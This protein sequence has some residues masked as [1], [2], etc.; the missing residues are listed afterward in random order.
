MDQAQN[1]GLSTLSGWIISRV[2]RLPL[3][4]DGLATAMVYAHESG[5]W[6]M[7]GCSGDIEI[8]RDK[9]GRVTG[10]SYQARRLDPFS[11][12]R[13]KN[14]RLVAMGGPLG[15]FFVAAAAYILMWA[16]MP[17]FGAGQIVLD[18]ALY[19]A[20]GIAAIL[21]LANLNPFNAESDLHR[22]LLGRK[23]IDRMYTGE[24]EG[25][26]I[27]EMVDGIKSN[28]DIVNKLDSSE[29]HK[30][31]MSALKA[32]AETMGAHSV[33]VTPA[34]RRVEFYDRNDKRMATDPLFITEEAFNELNIE[35]AKRLGTKDLY[36]KDIISLNDEKQQDEPVIG[37]VRGGRESSYNIAYS[38]SYIVL[39]HINDSF[40]EWNRSDKSRITGSRRAAL[41][42]VLPLLVDPQAETQVLPAVGGLPS[43]SVGDDVREESPR[44]TLP[45]R[46]RPGATHPS[47]GGLNYEQLKET[48]AEK[49]TPDDVTAFLIEYITTT[50]LWNQIDTCRIIFTEMFPEDNEGL[51]RFNAIFIYGLAQKLI[52]SILHFT[53][54]NAPTYL[55]SPAPLEG[56]AKVRE[57]VRRVERL[58]G[59][60]DHR[61]CSSH[62]VNGS[63]D[64]SNNIKRAIDA[65]MD[66]FIADRDKF[67]ATRW[68]IRSMGGTEEREEIIGHIKEQLKAYFAKP[69]N[70]LSEKQVTDKAEN[71]LIHIHVIALDS[72]EE[73]AQHLNPVIDLMVDLA[74]AE[75]DRYG[76]ANG[77]YKDAAPDS[78][79]ML[80]LALLNATIS[81]FKSLEDRLADGEDPALGILRI[82]FSG[83]A[84]LEIRP[85]DWSK[86]DGIREAN[87]AIMR[88]L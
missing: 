59:K 51:D 66:S 44:V 10:G 8:K 67:P 17:G 69:E 7:D 58:L 39:F 36:D 28:V 4:G 13:F 72:T 22:I 41:R 9:N 79:K 49:K 5:H 87:N 80:F 29:R 52:P 21:E 1:P 82:L 16:V 47:G 81:N 73:L 18:A 86:L 50:E 85:I 53:R 31:V 46:K 35:C 19:G 25:F 11:S 14:P 24:D 2:G 88:S 56:F 15:T 71:I 57:E 42:E 26:T 63:E 33:K 65:Q 75:I 60:N 78:L 54:R 12:P 23:D 83:V 43:A 40:H 34:D 84:A 70:H 55:T 74:A 3:V 30:S 68:I 6:F 38:G 27:I 76:G 77:P 61:I 62:Y 45:P 37:F 48:C 32:G 64:R 20:F